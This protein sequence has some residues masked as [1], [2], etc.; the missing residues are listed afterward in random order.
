MSFLKHLF[1]PWRMAFIKQG[2][3]KNTCPLCQ[4]QEGKDGPDNLI[5]HQSKTC[6][7]VMN[8]YPYTCGHI[9][10]VPKQH[11]SALKTIEAAQLLE[12]TALSWW[13]MRVL[14][15]THN[16]QG[17]NTGMNIGKAAGAGIPEHLHLHVVPRWAG[18]TNFMPIT[19]GTRVLPETVETT[20]QRLLDGMNDIKQN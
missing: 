2:A 8:K 5:L 12:M 6:F 1:T 9:M 3:T 20:Y 17:F 14:E 7:V 15:H 19:A 4:V 13:M 10:V 16:P 18:D 11:G